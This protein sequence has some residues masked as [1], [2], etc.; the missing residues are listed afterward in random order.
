[1]SAH[2][3]LDDVAAGNPL[4]ERQLRELR[5]ALVPFCHPDLSDGEPE[6]PVFQEGGA[7]LRRRH[8][9]R[10]DKALAGWQ[11]PT[12]QQWRDGRQRLFE[13]L[14]ENHNVSA[15]QD[16]LSEIERIVMSYMMTGE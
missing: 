16:D 1:M 9:L 7:L 4:A 10:A 13:Y 2:L 6:E 15:L 14:D 11:Y 3:D 12:D 5:V 8:F